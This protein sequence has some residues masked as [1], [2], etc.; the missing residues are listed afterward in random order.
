VSS[1]GLLDYKGVE[2]DFEEI[3][4]VKFRVEALENLFIE[5]ALDPFLFEIFFCLAAQNGIDGIPDHMIVFNIKN[6]FLSLSA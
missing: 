3:I 4:G 1:P 6:V 2:V 5:M